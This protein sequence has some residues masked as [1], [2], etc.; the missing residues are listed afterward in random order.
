[1]ATPTRR[2]DF[3]RIP[4][5]SPASVEINELPEIDIMNRSFVKLSPIFSKKRSL[6]KNVMQGLENKKEAKVVANNE[7]TQ[8][9]YVQDLGGKKKPIE[10]TE[11]STVE[12]VLINAG[13]QSF[14]RYVIL[15]DGEKIEDYDQLLIRDLRVQPNETLT[16]VKRL[17][18]AEP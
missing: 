1:M 9:V 2:L 5:V 12:E 15:Y 14:G 7:N 16:V 10:I 13:Y 11:R 4:D 6:L 18:G 17:K 8:N 3:L